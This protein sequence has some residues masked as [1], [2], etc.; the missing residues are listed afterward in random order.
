MPSMDADKR[1]SGQRI[2]DNA[3]TWK[4]WRCHLCGRTGREIGHRAAR[5]AHMRHYLANHH[6]Q[7]PP[8]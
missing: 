7:E 5:D 3:G 4:Q 6:D 8:F 1:G 2:N